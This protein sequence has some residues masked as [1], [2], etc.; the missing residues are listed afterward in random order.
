MLQFPKIPYESKIDVGIVFSQG[1]FVD[2][3][4]QIEPLPTSCQCP[5]IKYVPH[6]VQYPTSNASTKIS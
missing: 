5:L 6:L 1:L 4:Q 3:L 2:L